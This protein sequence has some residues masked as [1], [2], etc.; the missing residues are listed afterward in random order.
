M[1]EIEILSVLFLELEKPVDR[2]GIDVILT[3][4]SSWRPPVEIAGIGSVLDSGIWLSLNV[5]GGWIYL[6]ILY[7]GFFP[8]LLPLLFL[9]Y[10]AKGIKGQ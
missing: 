6:A 10:K 2:T 7:V 9:Q 3:Q 1:H 8:P 5:P 4:S